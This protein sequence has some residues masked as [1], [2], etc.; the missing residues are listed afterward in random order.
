MSNQNKP[1][2]YVAWKTVTY[3]SVVIALDGVV[4]ILGRVC[5]ASW[6]FLQF[7]DSTVKGGQQVS[8]PICS[9]K[10][11]DLRLR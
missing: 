5:N 2:L 1:G 3:R 11:P 9:R 6:C 10:L 4:V 8:L 7:T